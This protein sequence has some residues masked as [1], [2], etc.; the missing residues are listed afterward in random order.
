MAA[1]TALRTSSILDSERLMP[2]MLRVGELLQVLD[3]LDVGQTLGERVLALLGKHDHGGEGVRIERLLGLDGRGDCGRVAASAFAGLAGI[4]AASPLAGFASADFL[5]A[6]FAAAAG[7]G[8]AARGS[9]SPGICH[10]SMRLVALVSA[11]TKRSV[12][13]RI[14]RRL[15][16]DM[17]AVER[18]HA[19][20]GPELNAFGH[21]RIS[22]VQTAE[23]LRR[24]RLFF[25]R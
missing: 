13:S 24:Q 4:G 22:K 20:A 6:D 16:R 17:A 25:L 12:L 21:G 8:A 10:T 1:S 5:S 15:A 19:V 23:P 3:A 2:K 14:E 18:P 9:A 11:S 7:A